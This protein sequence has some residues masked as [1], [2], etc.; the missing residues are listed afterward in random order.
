MIPLALY[1]LD[2]PKIPMVLVDFR[3]GLNPKKRENVAARVAGRDAKQCYLF[4][5]SA[6]CPIFWAG[7]SLTL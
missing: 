2:N 5:L 7:P 6:T 1:G 3:D 4:Q